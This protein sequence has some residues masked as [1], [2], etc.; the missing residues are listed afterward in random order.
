MNTY[1][2]TGITYFE[3]PTYE[4]IKDGRT[5]FTSPY[6]IETTHIC[7]IDAF[8]AEE[9]KKPAWLRASSCLISCSCPKCSTWC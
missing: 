1:K 2:G 9:M 7:L 6:Q 4:P 3:T 8:F 5:Y